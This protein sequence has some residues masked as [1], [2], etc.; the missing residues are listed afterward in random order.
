MNLSFGSET[1]LLDFD[2]VLWDPERILSGFSWYGSTWR[3]L[4][5][6]SEDASFRL[7]AAISRRQNE[8]YRFLRLGKTLVVFMPSPTRWYVDTGRRE[9]SGTGR[10]RVTTTIVDSADLSQVLPFSLTTTAGKGTNFQ[11][12]SGEPFATFAR[13][14]E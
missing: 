10:N 5:S 13:Q 7:Q 4:P 11:V 2:L 6:L 14:Q 8:F 1:S 3:G 12:V 9:Y